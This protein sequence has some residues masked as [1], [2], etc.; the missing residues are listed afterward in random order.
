MP[1][2]IDLT[3][4]WAIQINTEELALDQIQ[5]CEASVRGCR[6]LNCVNQTENSLNDCKIQNV[7]SMFS[8]G[9]S[10]KRTVR[11]Y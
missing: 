7:P 9:Q 4:Q 6:K 3:D 2:R 5:V 8:N 11:N 1:G 10:K